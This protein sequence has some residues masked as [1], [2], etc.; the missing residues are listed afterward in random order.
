MIGPAA[1]AAQ[2]DADAHPGRLAALPDG[3]TLNFRCRGAGAPTVIFE[4]G[5][6]GTSLAWWKV[7]E[8]LADRFRSCAYDRAGYGFSAPGPAPR[9]GEAVARDLDNGLT[10]ARERG[11]FIL[12]GHSAG[13]LYVRLLADRRPK[14]VVG[15]V[16]VDPSVPFQ[17]R[18]AAAAYGPGAGA[19]TAQRAK[20][21]RCLAAV[22]SNPAPAAGDTLGGCLPAEKPGQSAASAAARRAEALRPGLWRTEIS[23]LDSLWTDTSR[24]V[25]RGGQSLA[26][27]PL[28]VLTADGTASFAGGARGAIDDWTAWHIELAAMSTRG[29]QRTI[30]NS[31]HLMMRDRPEAIVAAII[32]V[33]AL[34]MRRGG[35]GS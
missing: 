27:L 32:D 9:D 8:L 18:R 28:I 33:A 5:Y 21:A 24:E 7:Q 25:A 15:M 11:P 14:D 12:V 1:V 29:S 20:A 10:A 13:A 34:S 6:G 19:L 4:A 30:A 35:R 31:S 2:D 22:E 26:H 17:D 3:R 23:E 16:L